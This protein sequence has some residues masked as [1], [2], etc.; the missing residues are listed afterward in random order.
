MHVHHYVLYAE[1]IG[2]RRT[3]T[4]LHSLI[5]K[6]HKPTFQSFACYSLDAMISPRLSILL[7]V[8]ESFFCELLASDSF[9]CQ[10]LD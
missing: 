10:V 4:V 7:H 2:F 1:S 8:S 3:L 6:S 9:L 5:S